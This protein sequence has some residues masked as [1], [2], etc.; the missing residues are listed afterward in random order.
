[1]DE[2]PRLLTV[3]EVGEV[4]RISR[5][6]AYALMAAGDLD[7]VQVGARRRVTLDALVEFIGRERE[8][9]AAP[10]GA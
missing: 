3:E 4:L 5:S 2:L 9:A 6:Q 7:F 1:M 8:A 10:A